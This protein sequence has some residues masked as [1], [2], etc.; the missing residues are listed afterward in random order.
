MNPKDIDIMR[1]ELGTDNVFVDFNKLGS[2]SLPQCSTIALLSAGGSSRD[3]L[4]G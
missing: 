3:I 4:G 2:G 1:K